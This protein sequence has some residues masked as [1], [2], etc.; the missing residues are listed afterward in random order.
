MVI[1]E[2]V[3]SEIL[4][5][6]DDD[7]DDIVID[8]HDVVDEADDDECDVD[9]LKHDKLHDVDVEYYEKY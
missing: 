6:I 5:H 1:D 9:M 8:M 7:E 2:I 4:Q 3:H